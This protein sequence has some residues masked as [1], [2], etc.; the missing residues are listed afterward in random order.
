MAAFAFYGS[1]SMISSS[2]LLSA[3]VHLLPVERVPLFLQHEHCVELVR[4]EVVEGDVDAQVERRLKVERAPDQEGGLGVLGG[5]ER[6]ERAGVSPPA[7][8]RRVRAKIRLAQLVAPERPMYEESQ[9][10]P[11]GPLPG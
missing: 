11:L 10:G 7:V 5:V 6:I 8:L 9:G 1:T 3:M 2:L 4:A